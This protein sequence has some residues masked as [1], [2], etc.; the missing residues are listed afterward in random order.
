MPKLLYPMA[1]ALPGGY[2]A[3]LGPVAGPLPPTPPPT[4]PPPP[5][6]NV[7]ARWQKCAAADTTQQWTFDA[8]SGAVK[9]A[10]NAKLCLDV[11]NQQRGLDAVIDLWPCNAGWNQQWSVRGGDTLQS[12]EGNVCLGYSC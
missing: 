5:P 3:L 9:P 4:L 2:S 12:A 1:F 8:G 7:I 10:A 6:T 11:M